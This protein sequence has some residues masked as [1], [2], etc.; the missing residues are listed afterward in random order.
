MSKHDKLLKESKRLCWEDRLLHKNSK[1]RYAANID[2]KF[3][4]DSITD[5]KDH[6]LVEFGYLFEKTV[7]DSDALVQD[8]ALDALIA[9]LKAADAYVAGR[10]AHEVCDAVMTKCVMG[11]PETMKKAQ[12]VF[13]L[14]VELEAVNAFLDAMEKAIKSQV[15]KAVLLA[16]DFMIQV[17]SE[18]GIDIVP[19]NRIAKVLLEILDRQDQNVLASSKGLTRELC[20]WLGMNPIKSVLYEK[21]SDT[22]KEELDV[23]LP[24][25]KVTV[26]APRRLRSEPKVC[27]FL[28]LLIN[29]TRSGP[30][31]ESAA[32][33]PLG[34]DE[35]ELVDPVD[36]LTPLEKSG[37]WNNVKSRKWTQRKEA[38]AKLTEL[39]STKRVAPGDYTELCRTLKKLITDRSIFVRVEAVRAIG[40]LALELKVDFSRCSHIL[41]PVLLAKLR[42][43]KPIMTEAL[44]NTLQAIHKAECVT[45][46][47]IITDVKA[48]VKSEYPHVCSRTLNWVMYCIDSSNKAAILKVHKDYVRICLE[49]LNDGTAEVRDAAFS[50]LVAIE[51]S[52]GMG[53]LNMPLEKLDDIR[54]KK[55]SEMIGV[56]R[57]GTPPVARHSIMRQGLGHGRIVKANMARGMK[58]D[59]PGQNNL[60]EHKDPS[61]IT[62]QLKN[63][64]WKEPLEEI[65]QLQKLSLSDSK[66]QNKKDIDGE[67]GYNQ[68]QKS[69]PAW[70]A[71]DYFERLSPE[72]R[73]AEVRPYQEWVISHTCTTCGVLDYWCR[74]KRWVRLQNMELPQCVVPIYGSSTKC[75]LALV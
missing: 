22:M 73:M 72:E 75:E 16:I 7:S 5:P 40:N 14:W 20:R 59:G 49:R 2:L 37:F 62:S 15:A 68:F 8:K 65:N 36:I 18:F 31:E 48:A 44:T 69:S 74:C 4:C 53:L 42:E 45:L 13:M 58:A 6:R 51:K 71:A 9:Y 11:R 34:K 47:N 55:L 67:D 26:H 39:A 57:G 70:C 66:E 61:E 25:V 29:G 35:Y 12:T 17:L 54:R 28:S 41:L 19:S 33:I 10:Y 43:K 56:S 64:A 63:A 60:V 38:V 3:L 23:E 24:S 1:V 30:S 50:V 46:A 21:M 52:V 27:G 32:E